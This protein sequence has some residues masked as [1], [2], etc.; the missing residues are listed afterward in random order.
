MFFGIGNKWKNWKPSEEYLLK[1]KDLTTIAKLHSFMQEFKYKWDTITIL[2]WKFLWDYWQMPDESVRKM[3]GDCEDLAILTIDILGRIQKRNDARFIMS[4]G[5]FLNNKDKRK[6][7]GH[8]VTAFNNGKGKYNIF[9]NNELEYSYKDFLEIGHRFYP[10][11]LKYQ[12]I[13]DW[14]GKTLSRKF[15]LFGI[16]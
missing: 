3:E 11:G 1:V 16:F 14:Q 9:S 7:M 2:F 6:L 5:Y 15:K 10:L 12:E 8:C 4:F 13:R